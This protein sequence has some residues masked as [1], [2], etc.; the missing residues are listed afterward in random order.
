M[1]MIPGSEKFK[2][3]SSLKEKPSPVNEIENKIKNCKTFEELFSVIKR[4]GNITG[5]DDRIYSAEN[6][7]KI[8]N[9]A[10]FKIKGNQ[11]KPDDPELENILSTITRTGELRDKV[12]IIIFNNIEENLKKEIAAASSTDKLISILEAA[13]GIAR[14]DGSIIDGAKL[15]GL[16]EDLTMLK[17]ADMDVTSPLVRK[18]LDRI[19]NNFKLR[20]R[21]KK[22]IFKSA[23]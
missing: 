22:L 18:S 16:I 2:P 12:K 3:A 6:L 5:S 20:D 7:I 23:E 1:E 10:V 14:S 15:K 17:Q 13:G 4:F 21:V 8:I 11:M 19:T 9:K